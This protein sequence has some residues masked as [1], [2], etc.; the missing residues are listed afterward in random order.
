[1]IKD[2]LD[3]CE[4]FDPTTLPDDMI[5]K[6]EEKKQVNEEEVTKVKKVEKHKM[7]DGNLYT[8]SLVDGKKIGHGTLESPDGDEAKGD[9]K[10]DKMYGYFEI[11]YKDKNA[12]FKGTVEDGKAK[13][14]YTAN[15][16]RISFEGHFGTFAPVA[17]AKLTM[18]NG[19]IYHGEM[20]GWEKEGHGALFMDDGSQYEG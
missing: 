6:G 3:K 13:G 11:T 12:T 16:V 15:D 19:T 8:G 20:Q 14:G 10:D 7:E 18:P 4:Q 5:S 17:S 2:T 9:F 1:M